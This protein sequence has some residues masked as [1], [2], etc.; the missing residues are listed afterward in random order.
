MPLDAGALTLPPFLVRDPDRPDYGT[1]DLRQGLSLALWLWLEDLAPGQMVCTNRDEHGRGFELRTAKQGALELVLND[2][3]TES[4]WTSDPGMLQT[5]T[6]HHVAVIVDGGPKIISFVI[7]GQ[8]N[9]GGEA[10]QFGWGCY[11]PHLRDVNSAASL[12]IAPDLHGAV[13]ALRIY[14]R[15]LFTAEAVAAFRAGPA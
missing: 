13:I 10:R 1:K 15:A 11:N 7:D 4:R 6:M 12:R 14:A 8:F 9:D 2:G 5:E 3:R